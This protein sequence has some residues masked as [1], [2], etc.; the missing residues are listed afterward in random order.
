MRKSVLLLLSALIIFSCSDEKVKDELSKTPDLE[1]KADRGPV[2]LINYSFEKGKT[3]D[4][5]L[6]TK[7]TSSQTIESDTSFSTTSVQDVTYTMGMEIL[8]VDIN[9]IADI[10]IKVKKIIALAEIDGDKVEYDSKYIYSSRERMLFADYEAIKGKSFKVRVSAIGEVLD[11]YDVSKIVNELLSIKSQ[12]QKITSDQRKQFEQGFKE[13]GL[14]PLV[15]QLFK[16]LTHEKVGIESQWSHKYPSML[17]SFQIE[18]IATFQVKE[19]YTEN[20]D[21][22]AKLSAHLAVRWFGDNQV[23]EQGVN[24]TFGDPNI[25]GFGTFE[26][27]LTDGWVEESESTVRMEMDMTMDSFDANQKPLRATKKDFIESKNI[28]TRL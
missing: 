22:L 27:N 25:S 20:D 19:F 23:Q 2:K 26:F 13:Q 8:K 15:Q 10:A 11:I 17:G 4:Y 16:T 14:A 7:V 9:N 21:S 6:K 24:Y 28:L 18:N 5:K 12:G 1:T 3:L